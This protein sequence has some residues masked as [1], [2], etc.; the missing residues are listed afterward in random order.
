MI[1]KIVNFNKPHPKKRYIY[2]VTGGSMLGELL[3][4]IDSTQ[5]K[6]SFLSIPLM[7]NRDII[8]D[9]F[10]FGL[11]EKIVE[12]VEKLPK[13]VYNVCKAQY[14]KNNKDGNVLENE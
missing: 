3:V 12:T 9:K 4:Y 7:K 6:H 10:I 13:N 8:K 1:Q 14:L 2:A 11:T 5:D